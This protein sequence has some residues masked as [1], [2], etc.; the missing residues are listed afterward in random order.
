MCFITLVGHLFLA[1]LIFK[2]LL[3]SSSLQ[4]TARLNVRS[5]HPGFTDDTQ[6]FPPDKSDSFSPTSST[7]HMP[8]VSA[9]LSSSDQYL[10]QPQSKEEQPWPSSVYRTLTEIEGR[11]IDREA[12]VDPLHNL[13]EAAISIGGVGNVLGLKVNIKNCD[14]LDYVG[15]KKS[16]TS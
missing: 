3:P 8:A 6:A 7:A 1:K 10:A 2:N 16:L 12:S 11:S 14:N 4:L 13:K 9:I 15:D 5:E